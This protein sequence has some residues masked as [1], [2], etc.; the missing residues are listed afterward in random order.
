MKFIKKCF[1][2]YRFRYYQNVC[3]VSYSSAFWDW[4]RWEQEIDWM[5]LQGINLPLA[6]TAQEAIWKM[7]YS[8]M[9]MT[10]QELDEHFSGAAFFAWSA[11]QYFDY[12]FYWCLF[13]LYF[14]SISFISNCC[15]TSRTGYRNYIGA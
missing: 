3:T 6:F 5:A 12:L 2:S 15:S 13:C 1:L 14:A 11:F 7:V 4:A 10:Q 9:G 8:E